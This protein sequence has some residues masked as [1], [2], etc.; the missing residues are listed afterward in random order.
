MPVA[1]LRIR[2]LVGS[3]RHGVLAFN[4]TGM[5]LRDAKIDAAEGPAFLIRD[6]AD[7]QLD[8]VESARPLAATPVIRLDRVARGLVRA[9]RAWPGT[10]TFLSA[11]TDL[12]KSLALESNQVSAARSPTQESSIDY[13]KDIDSPDRALSRR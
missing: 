11:A 5:E 8:H 1:G 4:T 10:D 7:L 2:D 3:G 13:W 12:L 9:S 6:S